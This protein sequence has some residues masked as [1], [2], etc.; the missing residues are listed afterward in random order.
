[1]RTR[2]AALCRGEGPTCSYQRVDQVL[3]TFVA[4]VGTLLGAL[5]GYLF[6][7][8]SVDR[9]ERKAAVLAYTGAIT[10][11]I[12]GQHDWCHRKNENREGPEHRAA[13]VE[14]HGLRGV[15]RQAKR[16]E[17]AVHSRKGCYPSDAIHTS[18]NKVSGR[19]TGRKTLLMI[20]RGGLPGPFH[21]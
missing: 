10:E 15:A 2:S 12:R 18:Q 17:D 5:L 21:R 6:Q 8:H 9:S 4:V 19:K 11:T 7:R 3:N 16:I 1:M 20:P 13:R 14:A